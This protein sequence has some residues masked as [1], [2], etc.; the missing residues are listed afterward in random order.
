MPGLFLDPLSELSLGK[1]SIFWEELVQDGVKTATNPKY[2]VSLTLVHHH[3]PSPG[4]RLAIN[5]FTA[6]PFS[7]L[8]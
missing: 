2:F 7:V 1:R 4:L 8:T 5:G 3:S 6:L